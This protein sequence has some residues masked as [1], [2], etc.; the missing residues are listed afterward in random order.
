MKKLSAFLFLIAIHFDARALP[1]YKVQCE[2]LESCPESI[3]GVASDGKSVCTGVLVQED[4][5]A[6]N[7]HCIPEDL[8][9][10]EVSCKG[11]IM[12]SFPATKSLAAEDIECAK[13]KW[14]SPPLKDSPL[15][16]D[17]AFL[18]L[19]KKT[20]RMK[21]PISTSGFSDG[22]QITLF[23]IDPQSDGSGLLRKS[24]CTTIQKSLANPLFLNNKSPVIS[25]VPCSVVK[26]NSGSPLF[27][28]DLEVK[29]LLNSMGSATDVNLKKAPFSQVGY[30]SNFA[31]L[32]IAGLA[33]AADISPDC[34]HTIT[35]EEVKEASAELISKSIDPLMKAFNKDVATQL[36]TLH[37]QSRFVLRWSV[38]QKDHA[39][40]G[41]QAKVTE[42]SY[43]PECV[44]FKKA[45][46]RNKAGKLKS[47]IVTYKL[48]LLEWALELNL[49][50]SGRPQAKLI[51]KKINPALIFS[52]SK[53]AMTEKVPF[54]YDGHDL[55][56]PFC[57]DLP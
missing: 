47:E 27:S 20:S 5:I 16:P 3:V 25:L 23:K 56:I 51:S 46:L 29:G 31:C 38:D 52:P 41:L 34:R 13:V 6:T 18:R 44:N 43:K 48:E 30:G 21:V 50:D 35:P 17:Y 42:I 32:N 28:A 33:M 8:R 7:L 14:L 45:K 1:A 49:D 11:R 55:Q 22:E 53:L 26:G 39:F 15:T 19:E 57:E 2:S 37:E 4:L 9:K 40:D 10:E 36:Q 24:T 12:I 54:T